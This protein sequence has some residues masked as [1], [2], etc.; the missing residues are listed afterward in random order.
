MN[1]G[2][3]QILYK[4]KYLVSVCWTCMNNG[5]FLVYQAPKILLLHQNFHFQFVL[6]ISL[7]PCK[8]SLCL[9]NFNKIRTFRLSC[10]ETY[11]PIMLSIINR[12]ISPIKK[13]VLLVQFLNNPCVMA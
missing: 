12:S 3:E 8:G 10:Q 6:K 13:T 1:E 11:L 7:L 4:I 5:F 2:T 9:Y